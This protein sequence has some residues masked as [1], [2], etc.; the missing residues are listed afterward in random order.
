[1][2]DPQYGAKYTL[3]SLECPSALWSHMWDAQ[4]QL[5]IRM[6]E[7]SQALAL[8]VAVSLCI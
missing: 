1:M 6:P 3:S 8:Y 4:N 5:Y 7:N 2:F